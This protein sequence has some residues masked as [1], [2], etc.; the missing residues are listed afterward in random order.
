MNEKE[1]IENLLHRAYSAG[2]EAALIWRRTEGPDAQGN[3]IFN[4][5]WKLFLEEELGNEKDPTPY[6]DRP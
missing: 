4:R 6:G 2:W 3:L 1:K 5:G